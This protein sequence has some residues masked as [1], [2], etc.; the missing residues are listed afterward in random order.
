MLHKPTTENKK[1]SIVFWY[2]SDVRVNKCVICAST[3][4]KP[5]KEIAGFRIFK[6][7]N[8]HVAY[9][10]PFPSK[11]TLDSFYSKFEYRTGF[12]NESL[13]RNESRVLLSK[14]SKIGYKCGRVLDIGCGAGFF[15]DEAKKKG[16]EV[17]GIEMSKKLVAYAKKKLKLNI[18]K[19]D[20]LKVKL[21]NDKFDLIV[22]SQ[23]VE[24][25]VDPFPVFKKIRKHLSNNGIFYIATPNIESTLSTV[26]QDDFPYLTPPEHTYFY[27]PE[28]IKTLL[29]KTRFRVVRFQTYGYRQDLAGII[30]RIIME[31]RVKE[32]NCVISDS[33]REY[34]RDPIK[35]LKYIIFDK[36]FCFLFFR[37]LN[38][39]N[40]GSMIEVFA[41]KQRESF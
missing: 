36:F 40:K 11:K 8:C 31:K 5:W 16:W 32:T 6:C 19:G 14:L 34:P 4:L 7:Q 33:S 30:K 10:K 25:L 21:Y 1:I 13:L 17:S 41:S 26:L 22:L 15:L 12:L 39:G 18:K 35:L 37:F 2:N 28:A 20:F 29:E 9:I 23:V 24:H 3:T 27:G 38:P